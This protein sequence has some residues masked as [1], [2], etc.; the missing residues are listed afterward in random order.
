[1]NDDFRVGLGIKAVPQRLHFAP[2]LDIVENLAVEDQPDFA[3]FVV[4]RLLTAGQV[5][6]AEARVRHREPTLQEK[7]GAVGPTMMQA[8]Q[9]RREFMTFRRTT[10]GRT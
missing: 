5:D 8:A 2:Q 4:D 7:S 9:H 6:D 3:I 10:V 1:M